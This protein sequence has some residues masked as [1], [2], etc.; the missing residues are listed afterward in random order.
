MLRR[1]NVIALLLTLLCGK[2]WAC[3]KYCC[4]YEE[5]MDS[6]AKTWEAKSAVTLIAIAY[7]LDEISEKLDRANDIAAKQSDRSIG[8]IQ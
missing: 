3:E 8:I 7:K 5:C 1:I 6:T 2:A 4:S